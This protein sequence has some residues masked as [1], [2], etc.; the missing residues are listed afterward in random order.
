MR[1]QGMSEQ[2]VADDYL[3]FEVELDT[4]VA[5]RGIWLC[6]AQLA[7]RSKNEIESD[8]ACQRNV[9]VLGEILGVAAPGPRP[10]LQQH[11]QPEQLPVL[12]CPEYTFGSD[13]WAKVDAL[14]DAFPGPMLL[15]AGFGQSPLEGLEAICRSASDR[16][17]T[18]RRGWK[19]EPDRGGRP[20]NFG[21]VWA[22]KPDHSRE[23][24]LFGKNFLEAKEEDFKGVFQFRQLTEIVFHDLRLFPFIC[25][26]AL[27]TPIPGAGK[28]VSQRLARRLNA[29]HKPALCVGSLL[30]PNN[31]ASNT[32][33]VAINR[34]IDEFGAAE[35]VLII[36]NVASDKYD[37]RKNGAVWR[38][39]SGVYVSK[40]MQAKGQ[41]R[42]QESTGYFESTN[43]MGWPLRSTLPQLAFG[44]VSLPPYSRVN[45]KLHPWNA[46]P[47]PRCTICCDQVPQVGDYARS[48]LQD[49]LLLLSEVTGFVAKGAP[50]TL[51]HISNYV[52]EHSQ[53][54]TNTLVSHLLDGPLLTNAK[55]RSADDFCENC[56]DSLGQCLSYLD[57]L[58]EGSVSS[59]P[60]KEAQFTWAP[61][62]S[63]SGA[64]I[65]LGTQP[66]WVALWCAFNTT[67]DQMLV[68]L[69]RRASV[70]TD[71]LLR[72]FGKGLD[73]DI[74]PD[75]WKIICLET[76]AVT[77]QVVASDENGREYA[78][79][80]TD[81]AAPVE[82]MIKPSGCQP[83]MR[84]VKARCEKTTAEF[85]KGYKDIVKSLRS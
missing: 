34:L 37:A 27:E 60:D 66:I 49:E 38:N 80:P 30:Q 64:V 25:A 45:G 73:G 42:A 72:V 24:I 8:A 41:K 1:G 32:W 43:L 59:A 46:S 23:A 62:S 12:L 39:L 22:K 57:T 67:T 68:E 54:A 26:D 50:L 21:C 56:S 58:M 3:S 31:Q 71:G 76:T 85:M 77:A 48:W 7:P 51:V 65:R 63:V 17:V 36:S 55:P 10:L 47:K 9:D 15:I 35:V 84:L 29:D 61:A 52:Q 53:D 28:T 83:L 6:I 44:T 2:V 14:I 18:L 13:D 16:N 79:L 81:G 5:A 33:T 4:G 40:T 74:D 75:L 78:D 11:A 70:R 69:R 19:E 82:I 20:M